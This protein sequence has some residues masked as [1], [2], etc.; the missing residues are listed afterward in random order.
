MPSTALS[1]YV[2]LCADKPRTCDHQRHLLDAKNANR[3]KPHPANTR[4]RFVPMAYILR[5]DTRCA[6]HSR[7]HTWG[8]LLFLCAPGFCLEIT[9]KFTSAA[10]DL[11]L[12]VVESV[13]LKFKSHAVARQPSKV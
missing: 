12:C 10:P 13:F 3:I 8:P 4:L 1:N 2:M 5:V 11:V 6:P 9:T 7:A